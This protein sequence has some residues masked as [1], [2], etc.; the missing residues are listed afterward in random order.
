[1]TLEKNNPC[2][3]QIKIGDTTY[4]VESAV[5]KD[6]RETAYDKVKKLIL[7]DPD[8]HKILMVS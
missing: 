3:T 8:R 5:G 2:V 4:I 6:A 7:N 1:M